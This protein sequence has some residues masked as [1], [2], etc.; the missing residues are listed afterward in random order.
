[1][2]DEIRMSNDEM[3]RKTEISNCV[4]LSQPGVLYSSV[5]IRDSTFVILHF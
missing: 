2:N 4:P 5:V 3:N 1:M